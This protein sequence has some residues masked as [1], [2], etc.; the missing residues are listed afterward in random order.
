[1]RVEPIAV[2]IQILGKDYRIACPEGERDG[3]L[4]SAKYLE[5][6][7]RD[8]RSGG[9][10]VGSERIA[11]MAALNIAH[12]LLLKE[13][14]VQNKGNALKLRLQGLQERIEGAL[15]GAGAEDVAE[16]SQLHV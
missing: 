4:A 9:K 11:V 3:L 14:E 10:V 7:M 8:I 12:E 1:M 16:T 6:T 15:D 5:N 13:H 2:T